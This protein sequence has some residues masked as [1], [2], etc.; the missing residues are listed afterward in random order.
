V[1][2]QPSSH[3]AAISS[4]AAEAPPPSRGRLD[5]RQGARIAGVVSP[6]VRGPRMRRRAED[7]RPPPRA[8]ELRA[9]RKGCGPGVGPY[10][11]CT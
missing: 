10:Q 1:P 2:L 5:A 4:R 9:T 6:D 3:V 7:T 8:D 11:P